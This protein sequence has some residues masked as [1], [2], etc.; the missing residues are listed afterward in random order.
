MSKKSKI[1]MA[2]SL[3]AAVFTACAAAV[4]MVI[5]KKIY[6]KNYFSVND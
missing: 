5:C 4:T 2:V 6:E 1:F 3:T